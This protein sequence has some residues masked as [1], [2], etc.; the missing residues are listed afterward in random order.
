MV[1][2]PIVLLPNGSTWRASLRASEFTISTLAGETARMI[3][4]GFAIN[5]EM[6]LRVCFSMSAGWSPI[7]T[8]GVVSLTRELI[9]RARRTYF[10]ETWEI[11]QGEV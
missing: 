5:S 6:R 7:G 10:C 2:T 9:C 1:R 4:F 11:D 3:L 8:Y